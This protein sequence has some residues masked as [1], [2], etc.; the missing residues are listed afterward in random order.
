MLPL[1]G[2]M[3]TKPKQSSFNAILKVFRELN[4]NFINSHMAILC[5]YFIMI[6]Q[7]DMTPSFFHFVTCVDDET[8]HLLY[9]FAIWC[10]VKRFQI[11]NQAEHYLSLIHFAIALSLSLQFTIWNFFVLSALAT[12]VFFKTK[13]PEET[14]DMVILAIS[15]YLVE[16]FLINLIDLALIR[17]VYSEYYHDELMLDSFSFKTF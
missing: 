12:V 13:F 10:L 8:G 1:S 11:E 16:N 6:N 5:F 9:A 2:P 17:T 15:L 4:L 3:K 14:R 7:E